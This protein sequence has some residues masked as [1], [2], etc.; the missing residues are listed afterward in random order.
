MLNFFKKEK[1]VKLYTKCSEFP[2][3]NFFEAM[4][5]NLAYLKKNID[6]VVSDEELENTWINIL[7]E[8]IILSKNV[9]TQNMIRKKINFLILIQKLSVYEA[10]KVCIDNRVDV[11]A[12]LK[13]YKVKKDRINTKIALIKNDIAKLKPKENESNNSTN[14]FDTSIAMILKNGYQI[15]RFQTTVSEY[16]AILNSIE[17]QA[18]ALKNQK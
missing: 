14:D 5:G 3:H 2:V 1:K 4:N 9:V 7:D 17:Q 8:F 6:D 18:K 10:L 16:C 13:E 12:E 11:E 15:N